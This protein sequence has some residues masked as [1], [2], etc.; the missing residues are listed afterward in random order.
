MRRRHKNSATNTHNSIA[1][2]E[3]AVLK[4]EPLLEFAFFARGV[5]NFVSGAHRSI[6]CFALCFSNARAIYGFAHSHAIRRGLR[7]S[8][9]F[10]A[11][12]RFRSLRF[13]P[14]MLSN[15]AWYVV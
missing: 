12:Y 14:G 15:S 2:G 1:N 13:D 10:I 5:F 8:Y 3:L 11:W 7:G 9:P 6:A 4:D